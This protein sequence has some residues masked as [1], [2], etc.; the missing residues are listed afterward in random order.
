MKSVSLAAILTIV[1]CIC[2]SAAEFRQYDNP[3][4]GGRRADVGTDCQLY[5]RQAN[6]LLSL[7]PDTGQVQLFTLPSSRQGPVTIDTR[8]GVWTHCGSCIALIQNGAVRTFQFEGLA[9]L[10]ASPDSSIWAGRYRTDLGYNVLMR[11]TYEADVWQEVPDIPCTRPTRAICFEDDGTGWF[12]Y[13]DGLARYKNGEWTLFD[14]GDLGHASS[15]VI[16]APGEV[17]VCL[18]NSVAVYSDGIFANEYGVADGLAGTDPIAI[19]VDNSGRIWVADER[20]GVSMFDGRDW[21]IFTPLNSALS[22]PAV[23]AVAAS[24]DGSIFFTTLGGIARYR[25]GLWSEF[26]GTDR[27]VM[28]NSI[29]S[30]AV[31]EDG[32]VFYG[33]ENGQV[34]YYDGAAWN[35]LHAPVGAAGLD[36]VYDI[37]FGPRGAIWLAC[38]TLLRSWEGSIIEYYTAGSDGIYL[39]SS[40]AL[41]RDSED[42]IWVCAGAGLARRSPDPYWDSWSAPWPALSIMSDREHSIWVGTQGSAA[43]L[44]NGSLDRLLPQY[45]WVSAMTCDNDGH[46]WFGFGLLTDRGVLEFDGENEIAWYSTDDGLPSNRINCIACDSANHIWVGTNEGLGYFDRNN[47]TKYDIDRGFPVN[48]IRDIYAAPNGDVWFATPA[49]LICRESGIAPPKPTISIMT[50]ATAYSAG[51]TMAV[52]MSYGNPGPDISIDIY[53]ACQLPDGTLYYYPGGFTPT[54]FTSGMLSSGAVVPMV[55][56]MTYDFDEGFFTGDYI[57]MAGMFEQGTFDLV[58]NIATAPWRFE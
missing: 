45:Q 43:V 36:E 2:V 1:A 34:G 23:S 55:L 57:W 48:E 8:G 38:K 32:L 18:S 39:G 52:T 27:T 51:D 22:S 29:Y 11:F 25:A 28:N 14:C 37:E 4:A 17:W 54:P 30:V 9:E 16:S 19:D 20:H 26:A 53:T 44:K 49:G 6:R 13:S 56:V 40:R 12:A 42:R 50:D 31:S 15:M 35:K 21:V 46:L 5:Y 3:F 33:T 10:C 24:P 47:W 58:S 7:N 41:C